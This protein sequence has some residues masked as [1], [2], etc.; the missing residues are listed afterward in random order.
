MNRSAVTLAVIA[1]VAMTL[2]QPAHGQTT[3]RLRGAVVD[4]Q[5]LAMPG[6]TVT[7]R[8]EVLMGG[9]RTAV[10]GETGAYSFTGLPLASF[11]WMNKLHKDLQ[12]QGFEIIAVNV[13]ADHAAAQKF[14][15]QHPV[16]FEIIFDPQGILAEAH[17]VMGMPSSFLYDRDGKLLSS[18]IGFS[19]KKTGQ[20][21][22]AI[23]AALQ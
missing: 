7:I 5:G 14:I 9:S 10:T 12:A 20:L 2:G 21:R 23:E 8:S 6:V 3:G 19:N 4:Q 17:K 11:P 16:D 15:Q 1:G 13:D 18:H 22:A